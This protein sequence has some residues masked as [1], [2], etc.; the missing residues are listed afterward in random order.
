ML[1]N[2]KNVSFYH[3]AGKIEEIWYIDRSHIVI[4]KKIPRSFCGVFCGSHMYTVYAKSRR[5]QAIVR[6]NL[7]VT[8]V[9]TLFSMI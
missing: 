8:R 3:N 1:I 7:S 4:E 2:Y 9:F 6:Q 5:S